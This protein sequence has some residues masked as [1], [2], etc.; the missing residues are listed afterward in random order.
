MIVEKDYGNRRW[1]L[2]GWGGGAMENVE[3]KGLEMS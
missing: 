2:N 1:G 3:N